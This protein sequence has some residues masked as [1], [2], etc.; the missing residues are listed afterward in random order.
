L[1]PDRLVIENPTTGLKK[2]FEFNDSLTDVT[3][4]NY[5]MKKNFGGR[6]FNEIKFIYFTD[7]SKVESM[8]TESGIHKKNWISR[9]YYAATESNGGRMDFSDYH[10]SVEIHTHEPYTWGIQT[11]LFKDKGPLFIFIGNTVLDSNNVYNTFDA[12][13]FLWGYAMSRLGFSLESTTSGA[14]N[15]NSNDTEADIYAIIKGVIYEKH[16]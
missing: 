2:I 3:A 1:S 12:G 14:M 10:L 9:N 11:E 15:F 13:N 7:D 16:K 5:N 6:S 4:L 8:M